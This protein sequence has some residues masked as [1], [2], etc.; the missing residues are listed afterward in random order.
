MPALR[1]P[2][3]LAGTAPDGPDIIGLRLG[4]SHADALALVRCHTKDEGHLDLPVRWFDRMETFGIGLGPQAISVMTG[5]T[6]ECSFSSFSDMQRCG[7]GNRVWLHTAESITVATPG[8]PGKEAVVGIWRTQQFRENEMPPAEAVY[9]AL[10]EKYGAPQGSHRQSDRHEVHTWDMTVNGE[11]LTAQHPVYHQCT[12]SGVR[13]RGTDSQSW[14]EGCGLSIKAMLIRSRTNAD[15]VEE[16]SV[17]MLDQQRLWDHQKA[18]EQ[19]LRDIDA[20]RRRQE[21]DRAKDTTN[22]QL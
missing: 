8:L 16:I 20:E 9:A 14:T 19:G 11:P 5:D 1:C 21:L 6:E 3:R 17:G 22:V 12:N 2:P 7:P 4:M 18:F 10:M 13:P 15:L